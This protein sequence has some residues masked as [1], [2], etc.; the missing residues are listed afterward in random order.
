[1]SSLEERVKKL[2]LIIFSGENNLESRIAKLESIV[3]SDSLKDENA[4][5]IEINKSYF[6]MLIGV[7]IASTLVALFVFGCLQ[8]TQKEKID[9]QKKLSTHKIIIGK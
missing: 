9:L 1:M 8:Y 2:E 4:D 3:F 7:L 5:K 6:N